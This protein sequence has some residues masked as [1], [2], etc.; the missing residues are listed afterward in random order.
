MTPKQARPVPNM[1][2]RTPRRASSTSDNKMKI[3]H[4]AKVCAARCRH[5]VQLRLDCVLS[6]IGMT[7]E[8]TVVPHVGLDPTT[9]SFLRWLI[10]PPLYPTELMG[11]KLLGQSTIE[12][13]HLA[14]RRH[15]LNVCVFFGESAD[16]TI[17]SWHTYRVCWFIRYRCTKHVSLGVRN[18]WCAFFAMCMAHITSIVVPSMYRLV[19][20]LCYVY[21]TYNQH[22]FTK[23]VS[24]GVRYLLCVWH[25]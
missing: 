14:A 20:V 2:D 11:T 25:I 7:I 23:Q 3:T 12:S 16:T 10:R 21:G 5:V 4:C 17:H 6:L 15:F 19:C 22:S 9:C 8:K 1:Q 24:L 13:L 18:A